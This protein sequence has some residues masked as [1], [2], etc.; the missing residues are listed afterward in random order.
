MVARQ[1]TSGWLGDVPAVL[2]GLPP[3]SPSSAGVRASDQSG[4]QG[5]QLGLRSATTA[6]MLR[7]SADAGITTSSLTYRIRRNPEMRTDQLSV[8]PSALGPGDLGQILRSGRARQVTHH[9]SDAAASYG[10]KLVTA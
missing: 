5:L 2:H 8:T 6:L 3:S 9:F 7:I 10:R 4:A 1:S